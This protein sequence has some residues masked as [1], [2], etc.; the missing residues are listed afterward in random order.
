[1]GLIR[2]RNF[3]S[4]RQSDSQAHSPLVYEH[5]NLLGRY[6]YSVAEAVQPEELKPL[7]NSSGAIDDWHV[8]GYWVPEKVLVRL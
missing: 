7:R 5:I 4:K 8:G 2:R 6:A 3:P 1:M